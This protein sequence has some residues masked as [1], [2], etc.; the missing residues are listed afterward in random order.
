[1]NSKH[2]NNG[3]FTT[4]SRLKLAPIASI[5]RQQLT[6]YRSSFSPPNQRFWTFFK[7]RIWPPCSAARLATH[8]SNSNTIYWTCPARATFFAAYYSIVIPMRMQSSQW[9]CHSLFAINW[10]DEYRRMHCLWSW[11]ETVNLCLTL[12]QLR[13]PF[14]YWRLPTQL[15]GR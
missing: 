7:N 10:G 2:S 15:P 9:R 3:H 6:S 11:T 8:N 1:M 12:E 14:F 4:S 5:W 13:L